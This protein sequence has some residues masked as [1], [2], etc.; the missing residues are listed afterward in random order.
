MENNLSLRDEDISSQ[1]LANLYKVFIKDPNIDVDDTGFF[2]LEKEEDFPDLTITNSV[3]YKMSIDY[4][5]ITT[6]KFIK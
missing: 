1:I 5:V 2:D 3:H 4:R 6:R